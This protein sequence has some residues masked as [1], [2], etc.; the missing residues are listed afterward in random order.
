MGTLKNA[1]FDADFE[2]VKTIAKNSSL[3]V[4]GRKL[5]HTGNIPS[6]ESSTKCIEKLKMM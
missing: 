5:L 6:E 3:K 1:E 2:S 4:I